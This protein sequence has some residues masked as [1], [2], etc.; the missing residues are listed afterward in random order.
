MGYDVFIS[1]KNE[2]GKIASELYDFLLGN[3]LSAFLADRTINEADYAKMIDDGI[4]NSKNLIV[5]ASQA[6]Y[7]TTKWVK[8]EWQTFN[9][10]V[11]S[12]RKDGQLLT[13]IDDDIDT[14]ELPLTLRNLQVF[15]LSEYEKRLLPFLK[16]M[17][18]DRTNPL[19]KNISS[20]K[21]RLLETMP[22]CIIILLVFASF[23]FIGFSCT[24]FVQT[25]YDKLYDLAEKNVIEQEDGVYFYT[26]L[27]KE[28]ACYDQKSEVISFHPKTEKTINIYELNRKE[29]VENVAIFGIGSTVATLFK[30]KIKG[31]SKQT[32]WLYVGGTVAI[33]C[34]Y[35]IG[36][37]ICLKYF[38]SQDSD[39]MKE[40]L[41][42]KENWQLII[43]K[44]NSKK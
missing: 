8:H 38:P 14:G 7:L 32:V 11:L 37:Q 17:P 10:E 33:I 21:D 42:E 18:E 36:Q 16:K 44:I 31:N 22:V 19:K 2:D 29:V 24:H 9:N 27:E 28:D 40:F 25:T 30:S 23:F 6:K 12:G 1:Y 3:G 15:T 35:G 41:S 5:I 20:L 34:G 13:I 4:E 39:K 26:L 43:D